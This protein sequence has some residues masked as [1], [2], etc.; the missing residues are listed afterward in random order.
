M[1]SL[2]IHWHLFEHLKATLLSMLLT[3]QAEHSSTEKTL[4]KFHDRTH[5]YWN[6]DELLIYRLQKVQILFAMNRFI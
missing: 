1:A 4:C 6:V 2:L 5:C 3:L